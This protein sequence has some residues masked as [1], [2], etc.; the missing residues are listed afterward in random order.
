[1]ITN[2]IIKIYRLFYHRLLL[3]HKIQLKYCNYLK[4]CRIKKSIYSFW[5]LVNKKLKNYIKFMNNIAI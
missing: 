4:L 3:N 2:K 1:M 5:Y